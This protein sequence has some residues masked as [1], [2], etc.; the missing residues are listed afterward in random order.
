MTLSA[1]V[2]PYQPIVGLTGIGLNQGLLYIGVDGSD[3]EVNPQACFWDDQGATPATQPIDIIGGYP[4]RL[5]SP[6]RLY[7]AALYSI[8]VRDRSGAQ[9]FYEAHAVPSGPATNGVYAALTSA[10]AALIPSAQHSLGLTLLG[11][12]AAGDGGGAFYRYATIQ[13]AGPGKFQSADGAWWEIAQTTLDP[14][15]FGA[16]GDGTTDDTTAVQVALTLAGSRGGGIVCIQQRYSVNSLNIPSYVTV[17]GSG[18]G[19]LIRH[20]ALS[21]PLISALGGA[22]GFVLQDITIDCG[23]A[24][25]NQSMFAYGATAGSG[26]ALRRV[27]FQNGMNRW[28]VRAD[29]TAAVTNV[30]IEDCRFTNHPA[31]GVII[32]P[33]VKGASHIYVRRNVFDQVGNNVLSIHDI[34][35]SPWDCN[36]DVFFDDNLITNCLNTGANG[37]IPFEM[38]SVTRGSCS[39]NVVDSGTRGLSS[40]S[41]SQD[42]VLADNVVSNQ[43]A[44]GCEAGNARRVTMSS[45]RFYNCASGIAFT[46]G[47]EIRDFLICDNEFVGTGLSAYNAGNP[48]RSIYTGANANIY[49]LR[50]I[51]NSFVDQEFA[52]FCIDIS[53]AMGVGSSVVVS[54]NRMRA[55]TFNSSIN[56]FNAN[57][58]VC[59]ISHNQ[60]VRTAAYDASHYSNSDAPNF[61]ASPTTTA[62]PHQWTCSHNVI[63]QLGAITGSVYLS[64]IGRSLGATAVAGLIIV[65]NVMVGAFGSSSGA[66]FISSIAGDTILRSNNTDAVTSTPVFTGLAGATVY[67]DLIRRFSGSA[68]PTTGTWRRGDIVDNSVPTVGQP[69]GWVCTAAGSP[70]TWVARANL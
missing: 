4:M 3:P 46:S 14:R 28:A 22:T 41:F 24:A 33:Q 69:T 29:W 7:T 64:G 13:S 26:S 6:A 19:M 35:G 60:M 30:V 31:G 56:G 20:S 25:D 18:Q 21:A 57:A 34:T 39:R 70:G 51:D 11:Y 37:A 67:R 9:V 62:T 27:T 8:R 52:R 66:F 32:L 38:W 63:M 15:M 53:A 58:D 10:E 12:A 40:G 59:V 61:I 44:Y 49:G 47:I 16:I 5:G 50:I 23:S 45:N 42:V 1:V 36:F 48:S 65:D 68:A 2:N 17:A 43:T 55:T 54:G